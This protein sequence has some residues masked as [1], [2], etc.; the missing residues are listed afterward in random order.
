MG[1]LARLLGS[2]APAR[3]MLDGFV[4]SLLQTFENSRAGLTDEMLRAGSIEG[5]FLD[6]YEKDVPRLP[7]SVP[8]KSRRRTSRSIRASAGT[9]WR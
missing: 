3:R 8:L 5:F 7:T 6:L 1:R 2:K 9:V 4:D